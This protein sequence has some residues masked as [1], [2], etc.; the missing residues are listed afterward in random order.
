VSEGG[1]RLNEGEQEQN[2]GRDSNR[3]QN[4]EQP[5]GT[6]NDTNPGNGFTPQTRKEAI[7]P[8]VDEPDEERQANDK[9]PQRDVNGERLIYP[10]QSPVWSLKLMNT[11]PTSP[12]DYVRGQRFHQLSSG[13]K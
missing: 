13:Q 6:D 3:Q 11:S 9:E 10:L 8:S 5:E 4:H 12:A 7:Y 1:V 2:G